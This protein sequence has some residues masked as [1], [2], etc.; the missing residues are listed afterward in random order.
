MSNVANLTVPAVKVSLLVLTPTLPTGRG[1]LVSTTQGSCM[2]R[3]YFEMFN[4]G[5]CSIQFIRLCRVGVESK[6]D[7]IIVMSF[8]RR[9]T[10]NVGSSWKPNNKN[11][12]LV[13]LSLTTVQYWS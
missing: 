1:F 13:F 5:A 10:G 9:S 12:A 2:C 6:Y 3:K 4:Q 11:I 8:L 7:I